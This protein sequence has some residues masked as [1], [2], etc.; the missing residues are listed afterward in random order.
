MNF[1]SNSEKSLK[2]LRDLLIAIA[3]IPLAV[4]VGHGNVRTLRTRRQSPTTCVTN[5]LPIQWV[6]VR[7]AIEDSV[8]V[9]VIFLRTA[10]VTREYAKIHAASRSSSAYK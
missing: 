9:R 8:T 6:C 7:Y 10:G 1:R 5:A 4:S 3:R 2:N